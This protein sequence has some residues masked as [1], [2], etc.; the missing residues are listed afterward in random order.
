MTA[1]AICVRCGGEFKTYPSWPE[2]KFCGKAC[3]NAARTQRT[4]GACL[5]CGAAF[6]VYPYSVRAGWGKYCSKDCYHSMQARPRAERFWEK[7][8]KSGDCWL[9]LGFVEPRGYGQFCETGTRKTVPAHRV[10]WELHHG[11]TIPAGLF[12]CHRCD[13]RHCVNPDHLWLG[14][15]DENMKDMTSK[16]RQAR[17]ERHGYRKFP[18]RWTGPKKK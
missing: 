5:A 7:V 8:D 13:V 9:W 3:Y 6:I 10:A 15:H 16:G 18:E 2:R 17:G 12:V 4:E 14:D 11:E 1:V